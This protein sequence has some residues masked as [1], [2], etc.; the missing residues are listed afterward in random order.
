MVSDFLRTCHGSL[1]LPAEEAKNRNLL[2]AARV[3]IQPG[4][5]KDGW[6]KSSS[7]Q[8]IGVFCFN[9][10]TNHNAYPNNAL[11]TPRMTLNPKQ[12]SKLEWKFRDGWFIKN[13]QKLQHSF[14]FTE[15]VAGEDV[16]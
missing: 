14:F 12:A 15:N 16:G 1:L 3:I 6:W 8:L 11:V 9:Q 13:T 4:K 7:S 2:E 5:N 10:S